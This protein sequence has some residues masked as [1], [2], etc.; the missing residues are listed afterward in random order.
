VAL[1]RVGDSGR[2][3][4]EKGKEGDRF[5]EGGAVGGG[6]GFGLALGVLDTVQRVEG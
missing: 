3:Q 1:Y 6:Y 4:E 5:E 2:C